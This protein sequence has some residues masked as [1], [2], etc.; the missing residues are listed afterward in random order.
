GAAD[1]IRYYEFELSP[2]GVL[3]D[4]TIH[5]PTSHRADMLTDPTWD[6]PNI[7]WAV[8]RGGLGRVRPA[9]ATG[10]VGGWEG[11]AH[12]KEPS[13]DG[14]AQDRGA[15]ASYQD[16]WAALAIPWAAIAPVSTPLP[17]IWRANFYRIERPRDGVPE[18]SCWSPTLTDPADFHKPARFG[19]LEL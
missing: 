7:L 3:F 10:S 16:W 6:C 17:P 18:F 15:N 2:Q 19:A 1:P 8:G 11:G 12:T 13:T 4:A 14:P 9:Q 5:N